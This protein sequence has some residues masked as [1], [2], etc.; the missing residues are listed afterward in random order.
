VGGHGRALL[1]RNADPSADAAT[2]GWLGRPIAQVLDA[3]H[4]L[5]PVLLGLAD[6][7]RVLE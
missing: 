4:G 7:A 5:L 1:A 6:K 3:W 2:E